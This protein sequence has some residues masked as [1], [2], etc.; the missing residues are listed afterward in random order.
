MK[1]IEF[2]G[3]A[4]SGK[5]TQITLL[6]QYLESKGYSVAL[7]HDRE[8]AQETQ[9]PVSECLAFNLVFHAKVIKEYY[10]YKDKI[11]FLLV[12]RG[13]CDVEVWADVLYSMKQISA[14]EQE[15]YKACWRRFRTLVDTLF[16]FEVPLEI[17][18]E[19]QKSLATEE[20]D[21]VV[22]NK[23]WMQALEKAYKKNKQYFPHMVEIDG[24][25]SIGQTELK[26]QQAVQRLL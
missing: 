5:S 25:K 15:G 3:Q 12:D 1:V 24:T 16:Y 17:L 21:D 11:D 20:V 6:K 22:M 14:A 19:R 13:F 4:R 23:P 8:R 2:V 26:I 10:Q 7:V 9:V 18:F